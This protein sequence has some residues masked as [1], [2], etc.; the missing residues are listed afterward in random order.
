MTWPNKIT[1]TR[2]LLIP[3]FVISVLQVEEYPVFRYIT[4]A[5]FVT[6]ALGDALDGYVARRF[7]LSTREGKFIDPLADKLLMVTSCVMLAIPIWG[8]PGN[9]APLEP[10]VATIVIARD[11][12]ICIWVLVA[13]LAG[14][15]AVFEPTRLGRLTTFTQ[16]L[17]IAAALTGMLSMVVLDYIALPLSY[18]TAGLTIASGLQYLYK[19]TRGHGGQFAEADSGDGDGAQ[20]DR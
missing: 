11:V 15:K 2:M 9:R 17:M 1:Y 8:L 20:P 3:G 18:A 4:I 6:I 13:Y 12:F 7:N 5:I 19:H 10:E 16:M 14:E